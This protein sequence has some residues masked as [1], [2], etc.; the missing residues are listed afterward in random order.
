MFSR[1]V[2]LHAKPEP[3]ER[4]VGPD[5]SAFVVRP[6]RAE[7]ASAIHEILESWVTKGVI[8]SRDFVDIEDT[9]ESF[10]VACS[11]EGEEGRIL[12]CA[13]LVVYSSR[14]AE[15]RSVATDQRVQ[16]RGAGRSVIDFLTEW[17]ARLEIERVFLL[18]KTEE[19][20]FRCGFVEVDPSMLP[21][22]FLL[23]YVHAQGRT[24]KGKHVMIRDFAAEY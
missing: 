15:I 21:D 7:D 14:L 22:S 18:T 5:G 11:G 8:L 10:A 2:P 20:F 4:I 13:A 19:F 12:A 16:L 6:A 17:A 23:D 3:R 1:A 24:S 9:I